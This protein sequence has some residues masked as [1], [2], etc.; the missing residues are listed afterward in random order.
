M[1]SGQSHSGAQG[2]VLHLYQSSEG[3]GKTYRVDLVLEIPG[4]PRQS[5]TTRFSFELSDQER[6]DL[7]WYFEDYLQHPIDPAPQIAARIETWMA[8]KGQDLFDKLL[9]ADNNTRFLWGAI[10]ERLP[11]T[12]IEV[13]PEV[14]EA[15][16]IPW[17]L[18]RDSRTGALLA[19]SAGSFVRTYSGPV[20]PAQL[21]ATSSGPIR[22]LLVICR[23]GREHDVPFRSVASHI[24]N[25]LTDEARAHFILDVLRPPTYEHLS[26]TLRRARDAGE[27]YHV[28][29]FD[30]HGAFI[31]VPE[32]FKKW[33]DKIQRDKKEKEKTR[34]EKEQEEKALEKW[35][36]ELGLKGF[37]ARRYS[38]DAMYPRPPREGKR[39]YLLFE[40]P[41]SA[42]N[43]R[44]VD[45]PELG[46]LLME[47]QVP[48]LVLN[49][50]R[51][52][53]AEAP[54]APTQV[55][56]STDQ[57]ANL[58]DDHIRVRAYGSFAHE[59]ADAGV[60]GVVAMRYNVYVV[61]AAQFVADLYTSLTEGYTLGA[62]VRVGRRKLHDSP[63][64]AIAY[65]PV[66]L[67]DWSVPVVYEAA[68]ISLFPRQQDA[69]GIQIDP[70]SE[71]VPAQGD[72]DPQ[73]PKRPDVGFYGRDETLLALDR[74]FDDHHVA[75]LYAYAGSGK[76][77]TAAEFGRWYSLTG[78]IEGPVLFTSFEF[79][80]LERR[81]SLIEVLEGANSSIK[82]MFGSSISWL[83][84]PWETLTKEKKRQA[85]LNVLSTG[86]LLWVWDN[87][88]Q[89]AGFPTD[90]PSKLTA[91]EQQELVDFLRDAKDTKAKFLLT[92]R[93]DEQKWLGDLPA[94]V[95]IPPMPM[96][97]RL[98]LARELAKKYRKRLDVVKDWLPLLRYTQGNPLTITV[99]VGQALRAGLSTN[100]QIEAYLARLKA[101]EAA[102][103]DE[104]SEGRTKS[105]GASLGYGF[106]GFTEEERAQLALLHLF[107]GFVDVD[108]LCV[109]GAPEADWC[110]PA[111]RG[112]T[113]EAGI[114]LLNRA[115]EVGLLS[116][117]DDGYYT[118]HPAL[119][120][121]F[122]GLFDRFYGDFPVLPTRAY[123]EAMG[124]WGYY[125]HKQFVEGN[126]DVL[127]L[128]TVE[129]DNLLHARQLARA[130]GWWSRVISTMQGLRALY[131]YTGRRAEWRRLVEEIVPDFVD[132]ATDGPIPGR[133]DDWSV[134][135]QYRV[136]LARA[137]R[138]WLEVEQLQ[139]TRVNWARERASSSVMLPLEEL[140]VLQ[141]GT[142]RSLAVSLTDLGQILREQG[143]PECVQPYEEAYELSLRIKETR[144]AAIIAFNLGHT[145]MQ[146]HALG[147][148]DQAEHWYHRSLELRAKSDR[149]GRA[150]CYGQ[151][152]MVAHERFHEALKAGR[153]QEELLGHLNAALQGYRHKLD[154]LP[155]GAIS[156]FAM[157]HHQLGNTYDDAGDFDRALPHWRD[158]IRY[159][160]A[161]GNTYGAA[162]TQGNIAAA[163]ADRGRFDEA[164]LY[165]QA[166]LRNFSASPGATDDVQ[167]IQQTIAAIEQAMKGG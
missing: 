73:L 59:V 123:V 47:A 35:L 113:R 136:H 161:A 100:E 120:W 105:L 104:E 55:G 148:L 81:R 97:E 16:V 151:L 94:R 77:T 1:V 28:V 53:H 78:G 19:L 4:K 57:G 67:Q 112:L 56:D 129:E 143:N 124:Y 167:M 90:T 46:A 152:A 107:Q 150:I 141:R 147:D 3:D 25:S 127:G 12:R 9:D 102:F 95:E 156:E 20:L 130:N 86:T 52:A 101:G 24:V 15:T 163:F 82:Q 36:G 83:N 68:P 142:V 14:H 63:M 21:P 22:I 135:T 79:T 122:K 133:E 117:E 65:D 41:D 30:G 132:P 33:R 126:Q 64:R 92:S 62:A 74:A 110:L 89:V 2:P 34:E 116:D 71:A 23:P 29:H 140:S 162:Q 50:C 160:E 26:E 155:A 159:E 165:A 144:G 44:L 99:V 153:P 31:D 149:L 27:P 154:I 96:L 164:L 38:P 18:L 32:M 134:I 106:S 98:E 75:L 115:S 39:G 42:Y 37:D 118:I 54:P 91:E 93:R 87:V 121:Y 60:A 139:R 166:A 61:T 103:E 125:Y 49:A 131:D 70:K 76:T 80:S 48:V 138:L 137:S 84:E 108:T 119:P 158:S 17:E 8:A 72:L 58:T 10:R 51:S 109:M 45:G 6:E 114:P 11:E 40:N 66:R 85:T 43:V 69:G 5:A 13:S 111:V 88:E 157:V 128:L 7:R 145:Y 146:V